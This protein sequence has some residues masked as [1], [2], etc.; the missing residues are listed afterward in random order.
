MIRIKGL[1]TSIKSNLLTTRNAFPHKGEESWD[2][3]YSKQN[4]KLNYLDK[5]L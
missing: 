2:H 5:L 3:E 4:P 1:I